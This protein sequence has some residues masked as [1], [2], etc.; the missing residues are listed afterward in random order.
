[1]SVINSAIV[2]GSFTFLSR[3]LGFLRECIMSA[4]IGTTMFMD[5]F[6]V[7]LKLANTCRKI[8]AEGAFNSSFLPRFI[9]TME[10]DGLSEANKLLSQLFSLMI[11]AISALI[12]VA[13]IYYPELLSVLA[14]GFKLTPSKFELA[15]SLGRI[16]FPFIL[17]VTVTALFCGV[18]NTLKRFA[19]PSIIHSFVN[20][21]AILTV[22]TGFICDKGIFEI[23]YMLAASIIVSGV[24]QVIVMWIY[25]NRLGFNIKFTIHIFSDKVNDILKNMIPGLLGA[26]VW[27]INL[28]VD[29][30]IC[31][32]LPTGTISC[33]NLADKLNQF[34]LATFGTALG[35]AMLPALSHAITNN[36]RSLVKKEFQSGFLYVSLFVCPAFVA[37]FSIPEAIVATAFQRGAFGGI[38]VQI[39]ADALRAFAIGLPFH[40]LTK[41]YASVFFANKDTRSPT[42]YAVISVLSNVVFLILLVPFGKHYCV[43]LSTSCAAAVNSVLLIIGVRMKYKIWLS[44][45]FFRKLCAQLFASAITLYAAILINDQ[46]WCAEYGASAIKWEYT[47]LFLFSIGGLY[48][49]LVYIF[50]ITLKCKSSVILIKP[51]VWTTE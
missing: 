4:V 43:A 13:I 22:I 39:T 29:T 2:V 49:I 35:T 50:L 51:S 37:L 41:I 12:V 32:Y 10:Q 27:Q 38:F 28:L 42:V 11:I 25:I 3:V 7:G 46:L 8:F 26:G 15:I 36:D 17:F 16:M 40:V 33:L 44:S 18:A 23:V 5:C 19:L 14:S 30:Y 24:T 45:L 9:H 1:M 6:L 21:F 34:P 31:S 48:L 47:I 20:V